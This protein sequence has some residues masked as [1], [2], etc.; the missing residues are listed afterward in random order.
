MPTN[1]FQEFITQYMKKGLDT[2]MVLKSVT[3][4]L[5][6]G[7]KTVPI[8]FT[9]ARNVKVMRMQTS[10]L[11]SYRRANEGSVA[12][13]G[14][15]ASYNSIPDGYPIGGVANEW[16]TFTLQWDRAVQFRVDKIS[17][18]QQAMKITASLMGEFQRTKVIPEIDTL[19]ISYL[20]SV[21]NATLGNLVT[22][23]P[24]A[25]STDTGI[26]HCFNRGFEYLTQMG[27]Q[28]ENQV[29]YANPI[30]MTLIRNTPELF[31]RLT[32]EDVKVGDIN[33]AITKYDGR[34]IIEV[35]SDRMITNAIALASGG[36]IPS[37]SSVSIN[38]LICAVGNVIP[39]KQIE[40][41]QT[42]DPSVVQDFDGYKINFHLFHGIFVPF[43]K[44]PSIYVS[45]S[46]ALGAYA[47][48]GLKVALVPGTAT[49]TWIMNGAYS[50]PAGAIG[51]VVRKA[52]AFTM[53][54]VV[55]VDGSTVAYVEP[56]TQNTDTT[57]TQ[58]YFAIINGA[59]VVT[60]MT[61]GA[62]TLPKAS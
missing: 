38:Y 31:R 59:N 32:Q 35:P 44:I 18:M 23:T 56:G 57:A 39:I 45:T 22:E 15:Y 50:I 34:R 58:Y 61:D 46:T 16:D 8:E 21:A 17:D 1:N 25:T 19:R 26:I 42:F 14:Q 10:G 49:N 9:D 24:T 53:G 13:T 40:N 55:T 62:V 20:A 33:L 7:A 51:N 60:N 11:G 36:V 37:A 12:G 30:I 4:V 54:E 3:D 29:I 41:V 2:A 6:Q 47:N 48:G 43:N 52:T 5:E 27:V 28:N